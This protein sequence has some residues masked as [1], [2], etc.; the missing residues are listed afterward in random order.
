MVEFEIHI[1]NERRGSVFAREIFDHQGGY[2]H[3][4]GETLTKT[5]YDGSGWYQEFGDTWG[6]FYKVQPWGIG[7]N[8][9]NVRWTWDIFILED[10]SVL[11]GG[12]IATD[13]LQPSL[14]RH[15][16]RLLPDGSHDD[17]FPIV[18]AMPQGLNTHI[19]KIERAG[20]GSWYVSGRFEGVNGH[21]SPH[22]AKLNPDFSVDTDFV[23]PLVYRSIC[24][25]LHTEMKLLDSVRKSNL[26]RR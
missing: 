14:F 20:D 22:I 16:M 17:T 10:Q 25:G 19:S 18:E 4:T 26:V 11:I 6:D 9:Y 15:L 23:S 5:L 1:L 3:P 8:P 12:A 13:T 21:I 7:N 24:C 2:I